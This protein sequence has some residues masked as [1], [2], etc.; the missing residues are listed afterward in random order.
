MLDTFASVG[1]TRFDVT[2]TTA[3]G[4]KVSFERGMSRLV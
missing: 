2:R 1:A 3:A 4:D